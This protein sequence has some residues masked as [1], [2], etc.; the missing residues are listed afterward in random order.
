MSIDPGIND[1][2]EGGG[3]SYS[4]KDA[5]IDT[6]HKLKI[7][8]AKKVQRTAYKTKVPLFWPDGNPQMQIAVTGQ[9]DER[10]PDEPGDDGTRSEYFYGQKLSAL[11]EELK[12]VN[13]KTI[14]IDGVL[15]VKLTERRPTEGGDDQ[16]IFLVRYEAPP[17]PAFDPTEEPF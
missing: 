17:K 6:V 12:R 4:W 16:N 7:T 5:A 10:D 2:L 11:K 9:T 13:E 14:A 3:K 15:K 8:G 1:L